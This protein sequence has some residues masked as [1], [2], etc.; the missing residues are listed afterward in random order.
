MH[1][2]DAFVTSPPAEMQ[3]FD[4]RSQKFFDCFGHFLAIFGFARLW[5][6]SFDKIFRVVFSIIV[7]SYPRSLAVG[8]SK[9]NRVAISEPRILYEN[10]IFYQVAFLHCDIPFQNDGH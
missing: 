2:L 6:A 3:I 5:L 1:S 10:T 4:T 8:E 7:G 9:L